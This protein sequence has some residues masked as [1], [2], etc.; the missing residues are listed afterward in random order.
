MFNITSVW[1][2]HILYVEDGINGGQLIDFLEY[3]PKFDFTINV[4]DTTM[5]TGEPAK[6]LTHKCITTMLGKQFHYEIV[7]TVYQYDPEHPPFSL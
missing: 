3:Q 5:P 2:N 4:V 6:V 7:D 1:Y